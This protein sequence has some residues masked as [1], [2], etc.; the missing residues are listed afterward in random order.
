MT[1]HNAVHMTII[2]VYVEHTVY[3]FEFA[4]SY[5]HPME[6]WDWFA[7]SWIR[8]LSNFLLLFII[9]N[10]ISPIL[11]SSSDLR[12]KIKRGQ[13]FPCI[14]YVNIHVH[15]HFCEGSMLSV[16]WQILLSPILFF[17]QD[18]LIEFNKNITNYCE[19]SFIHGH[20]TCIFAIIA[21]AI[22]LQI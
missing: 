19:P 12:A 13:N 4:V 21:K 8:P 6:I 3:S 18:C 15:F 22:I 2:H 14:Q 5:V 11:N 20:F 9:S 7:P 16:I 10:S 1:T 17:L